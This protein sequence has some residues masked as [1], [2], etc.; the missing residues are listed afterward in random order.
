MYSWEFLSLATLVLLPS[1]SRYERRSIVA[2]AR[3]DGECK[4]LPNLPHASGIWIHFLPKTW[5]KPTT[6]IIVVLLD[7][8]T[9]ELYQELS[10]SVVP[11]GD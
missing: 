2:I 1:H 10:E 8:A 11:V 9:E 7:P 6:G 4:S 5:K 3:G